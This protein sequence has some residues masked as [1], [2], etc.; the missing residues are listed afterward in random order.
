[1]GFNCLNI[2]FKIMHEDVS[3]GGH[4]ISFDLGEMQSTSNL[5]WLFLH[6]SC[7]TGYIKQACVCFGPGEDRTLVS[8]TASPPACPRIA[9]GCAVNGAPSSFLDSVGGSSV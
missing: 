4:E 5:I 7:Q 3:S 1:M 8:H 2:G 9:D 6:F